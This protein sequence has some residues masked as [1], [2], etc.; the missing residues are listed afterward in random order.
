MGS[1]KSERDVCRGDLLVRA[2]D[3]QE[4]ERFAARLDRTLPGAALLSPRDGSGGAADRPDDFVTGYPLH[5]SIFQSKN[6]PE[7][8]ADPLRRVLQFA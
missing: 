8:E 7:I 2:S 4:G 3:N 1:E 6:E 5:P